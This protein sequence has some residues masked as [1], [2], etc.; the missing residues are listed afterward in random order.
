MCSPLPEPITITQSIKHKIYYRLDPENGISLA[1]SPECSPGSAVLY[2]ARH[3]IA[4][5]AETN[6]DREARLVERW[7]VIDSKERKILRAGESR[8]AQR[9]ESITTEASVAALSEVLGQLSGEIAKAIESSRRK[10]DSG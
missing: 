1:S 7:V 5:G 2:I 3:V 6:E 4:I 9:A 10:K 8:L